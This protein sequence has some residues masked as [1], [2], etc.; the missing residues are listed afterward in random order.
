MKKVLLILSIAIFALAGCSSDKKESS[1]SN[2]KSEF[3]ENQLEMLTE[4]D[5]SIDSDTKAAYSDYVDCYADA[6]F[7][8]L[9]EETIEKFK[10]I[11]ATTGIKQLGDDL[12]EKDQKLIIEAATSCA[13]KLYE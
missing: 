5:T 9:P 6:I 3:K 7:D 11:D 13:S 10:N 4:I 12:S 2:L 8:V 1:K